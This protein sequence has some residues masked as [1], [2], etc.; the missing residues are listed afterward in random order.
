MDVRTGIASGLAQAGDGRLD[1]SELTIKFE[2]NT[3]LFFHHAVQGLGVGAFTI[4]I[5]HRRHPLVL[6][7]KQAS[8][9][10]HR[11][12][13]CSLLF[14]FHPRWESSHNLNVPPKR[15]VKSIA[16]ERLLALIETVAAILLQP[17][18]HGSAGRKLPHA[19]QHEGLESSLEDG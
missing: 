8:Q 2:E 17:Y 14:G 19:A 12:L 3:S 9:C 16:G 6:A 4:V 7:A 1:L 13:G 10:R 11:G 15:L 5:F 18:R